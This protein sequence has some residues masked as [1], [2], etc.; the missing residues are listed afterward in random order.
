MNNYKKPKVICEIGCN[1][2]G[3]FELAKKMIKTAAEFCKTD[4]IKFQKRTNKELLGQDYFKPHPNPENSYGNNYG[5][6]RDAL[7]FNLQQHQ[8]LKNYCESFGKI[9]SSSVWDITSAKEIISLQPELIKIP[10]AMNLNF[11]L[12][13]Y[14]L[15][16]YEGDIHISLGMTYKDEIKKIINF[17]KNKKKLSNLVL[18]YCKSTYPVYEENL[19]LLEIISLKS[20]YGKEI[21]SIGFSGHHTGISVDISALTLGAQYFERHFTLNRSFKGTDHAASLEPDGLRKLIR[22]LNEAYESLTEWDGK[23][24]KEELFQRNKL[25]VIKNYE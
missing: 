14:V 10:S 12:L 19:D 11:I 25:K 24:E 2:M 22:N 6:H 5:E 21:K 23:I 16:N 17:F 1:H 9:Y 7:E 3:D 15:E 4:I 8:E 20:M 13:D 18:Y